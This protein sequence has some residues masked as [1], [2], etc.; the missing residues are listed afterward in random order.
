MKLPV[1]NWEEVNVNSKSVEEWS[2]FF[3]ETE[4]KIESRNDTI[5]KVRRNV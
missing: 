4:D 5:R 2:Q 1:S 3:R